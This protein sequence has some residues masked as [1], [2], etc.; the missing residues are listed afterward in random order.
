MEEGAQMG[1]FGSS[2]LEYYSSQNVYGLRIKIIGIPDY[3]VEH[4]SVPEQ[5][6][7]VGLTA[8]RLV[9]EIQ[10]LVPRKRQHA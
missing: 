5:R 1:G 9:S 4:G 2:I 6:K 3:F 10:S 7:E 8:E